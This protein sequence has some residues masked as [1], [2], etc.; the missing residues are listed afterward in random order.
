[1]PAYAAVVGRNYA[2]LTTNLLRML[3]LYYR[4]DGAFDGLF[5]S[6]IMAIIAAMHVLE[7]LKAPQEGLDSATPYLLIYWMV[8]GHSLFL[9][10]SLCFLLFI[11]V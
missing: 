2:L 6:R 7:P 10:Y 4:R 11:N 9:A 8:Y 5:V 3:F 1:M